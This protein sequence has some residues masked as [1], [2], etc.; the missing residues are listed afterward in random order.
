MIGA[1]P[2]VSSSVD[3]LDRVG[4]VLVTAIPLLFLIGRAPADIALS[5][6]AVLLLVRSALRRGS[7]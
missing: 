7:G 5:M 1:L 2:S 4:R 6:I 3:W